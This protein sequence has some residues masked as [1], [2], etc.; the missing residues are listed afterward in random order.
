MLREDPIPLRPHKLGR[1][2]HYRLAA[3]L[4]HNLWMRNQVVIPVWMSLAAVG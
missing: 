1:S 4:N 2:N 3:L